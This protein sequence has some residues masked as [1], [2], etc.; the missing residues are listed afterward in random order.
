MHQ[1]GIKGNAVLRYYR[2]LWQIAMLK[3]SAIT[4]N[5]VSNHVETLDMS[6]L[7]RELPKRVWIQFDYTELNQLVKY[8]WLTWSFV[9]T[10]EIP[11]D[12]LFYQQI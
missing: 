9:Y 12:E 4:L 1:T 10:Y 7:C 11:S 5:F 3:I 2:F 6:H 8:L